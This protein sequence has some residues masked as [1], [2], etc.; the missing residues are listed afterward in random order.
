MCRLSVRPRWD[1]RAGAM[2]CHGTR[3][4]GLMPY[5]ERFAAARMAVLAFDYR[6]FGTSG[7]QP[8]QVI[9]IRQQLED[10]QAAIRFA[11]SVEGVDPERIALWGTSLS[12]GH[13][14]VVAATDPRIAAVVS[15]VPWVGIERGRTSP[16]TTQATLK[17][18]LAAFR[19]AMR[20]LLGRPLT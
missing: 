7:G 5:A 1:K 11:R 2:H 19:D 17:L 3:D 9:N 8:R 13:V 14:I 12:G 10:Y 6:H 16:R 20:G 4:M 18:F 15:Q